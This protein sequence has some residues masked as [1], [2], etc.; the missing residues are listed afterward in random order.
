MLFTVNDSNIVRASRIY[1]HHGARDGFNVSNSVD[2]SCV[3]S[4]FEWIVD[5]CFAANLDAGNADDLGQQRAALF[6][7]NRVYNCQGVKFLGS[8]NVL[9]YGNSFR[10]PLNYAVYVGDD[11]SFG[12]GARPIEDVLI[13]GNNITDLVAPDLYLND[14]DVNTAIL[15]SQFTASPRNVVIRLNNIAQRTATTGKTWSELELRGIAGENRLWREDPDGNMEWGDDALDSEV[16]VGSGRCIRVEATNALDRIQFD[17]DDNRQLNFGS[18]EIVRWQPSPWSGNQAWAVPA[19]ATEFPVGAP[20]R[21]TGVD[22]RG[23]VDLALYLGVGTSAGLLDTVLYWR[24]SLDGGS[25]WTDTGASITLDGSTTSDMYWGEF[26]AMPDELRQ[27]VDITLA[28]WGSGGNGSTQVRITDFHA[29]VRNVDQTTAARLLPRQ[30]L[31]A[32]KTVPGTVTALRSFSPKDISDIA[33]TGGGGSTM[34]FG[35][36]AVAGQS[37]VVADAAP[38]TLTLAAGANITITT[39]ASTDTVTIA[40]AGGGTQAF[41]TIAVAGQS[42]VVADAAP[43]TLTLVAGSN[44]TLTTNA[45]TDTITIAA[46]GGGSTPAFGTISVSGQSDVVAD[47]APDTLTLAGSNG[48]AITTN[49][50]TDTVTFAP[51]Y[52]SSAN[53]VCQGNDSRLSDTRTPTAH[54]TSHKSGGGDAINVTEFG[55]FTT[56]KLAGRTTAGSGALEAITPSANL[57]LAG[58]TLDVTGPVASALGLT[59]AV[60]VNSLTEDTAPDRAADFVVTYDTSAGGHKKVKPQNLIPYDI[61]CGIVGKPS[62]GEVVLLFVAPRA[63]R[64]PANAAGSYLKAGTAATGSQRVL[65]PEERHAVPHRDRRRIRHHRH[66]LVEPD[67]L[68]R[69]RRAQDRGARHRRRDARRHRHHPGRN[70]AVRIGD[71]RATEFL[72]SKASARARPPR[73]ASR[74]RRR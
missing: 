58:G 51:T 19:S 47:A 68:R 15:V 10:A 39:N 30:V 20:A 16:F 44:I 31:P 61:L 6:A 70:P 9:V 7:G 8:K 73:R 56:G 22:L 34:A 12:Q 57:S 2:V 55:G 27:G 25:T 59:G 48:L 65:D 53:T 74:S 46:A 14:N 33:G 50:A 29:A 1:L 67:R 52:G 66:L 5:D 13:Y 41:G 49:A 60:S 36:I 18:D 21:I 24:Y 43:D 35:S 62:N 32:E 69:R 23:Y 40:A 45:S 64:I 3:D 37:N 17:I 54:A 72:S 11:E 38:D 26:V 28:L 71:G 63:F 42:D 4:D